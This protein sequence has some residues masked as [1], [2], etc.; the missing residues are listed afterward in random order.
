MTA[1]KSRPGQQAADTDSGIPRRSPTRAA[2]S[3]RSECT[4]SR[5]QGVTPAR[6]GSS[7]IRWQLSPCLPDLSASQSSLRA[8]EPVGSM[9]VVDGA[10]DLCLSH[11]DQGNVGFDGGS[12]WQLGAARRRTRQGSAGR[13]RQGGAGRPGQGPALAV[14]PRAGKDSGTGCFRMLTAESLLRLPRSQA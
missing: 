4:E 5:I 9:I 11:H 14:G 12:A 10:H 13:T 2:T 3:R 6:V 1:Q 8:G 7:E